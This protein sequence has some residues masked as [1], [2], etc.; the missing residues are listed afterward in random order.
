MGSDESVT[1]WLD[2]VKSGD[3]EAIGK[4]VERY[5]DLIVRLV[6][7]R[8]PPVAR[9]GGDGE[10]VA[11]SALDS[12]LVRARDGEFQQLQSRDDLWKIL[13]TISKRKAAKHILRETAQK[14]GG[15]KVR[16]ESVFLQPDGSAK[17][18]LDQFYDDRQSSVEQAHWMDCAQHILVFLESLKDDALRDIALW[19]SHGMT[20]EQIARQLDC[21]TKTVE[22]KRKRLREMADKWA[23]RTT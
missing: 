22:R 9:R 10:D 23:I 21:S 3:D 2:G 5:Y 15:G 1:Q 19:K 8:L 12:F 4:F 16:G 18:G 11:L 17:T 20:D 14:R 7:Q 13:V 6:Q